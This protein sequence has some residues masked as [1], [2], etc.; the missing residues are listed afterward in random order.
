MLG[1]SRIPY[2]AAVD[3]RF[4]SQFAKLH[5]VKHFPTF[6]ILFMGGLSA[7]ASLLSLAD[8]INYMIVFQIMLQFIAQ[9]I[10]VFLIRK[11][12]TDIERPF[13]MPLYPLPVLIALGGWLY[14]LAA[15]GWKYIV[16]GLL[17]TLLGT[18]AYLWRARQKNQWPF[19]T[20]AFG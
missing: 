7:L 14:I 18:A 16:S 2:G 4:F 11:Y 3:G 10:A 5:P 13:S 19:T 17:L 12:R 1:Y 8:L 20:N 6:S 15:S 9:C